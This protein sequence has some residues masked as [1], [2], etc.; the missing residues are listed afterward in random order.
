MR[1]D[2]GLYRSDQPRYSPACA[3]SASFRVSA[4][5][6]ALRGPCERDLSRPYLLAGS[7][8]LDQ[9]DERR[10]AARTAHRQAAAPIA[11]Q[12]SVVLCA[13]S[14]AARCFRFAASSSDTAVSA[15]VLCSPQQI[16]T[17]NA[18]GRLFRAQTSNLGGPVPFKSRRYG[19]PRKSA[20][21]N[22]NLKVASPP[23]APKRSV[24]RP[25][26][27]LWTCTVHTGALPIFRCTRCRAMARR[28]RIGRSG[29][30]RLLP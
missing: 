28:S 26:Q 19:W 30:R 15:L 29:P 1:D 22:P 7:P 14:L 5:S 24:D 18:S 20:S 21:Y 13:N 17:A 2:C 10:A 27:S 23:S 25:A 12:P 9:C 8:A 11:I 16:L 6:K 4:R 3:P